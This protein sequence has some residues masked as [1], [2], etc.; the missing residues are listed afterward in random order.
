MRTRVAHSSASDLPQ[1]EWDY[2]R[3][4]GLSGIRSVTSRSLSLGTSGT[5]FR[6]TKPDINV[7]PV[8]RHVVQGCLAWLSETAIFANRISDDRY[9]PQLQFSVSSLLLLSIATGVALAQ[10][11][12]PLINQPLVPDA[13]KPVSAGF[14]LTVN[15]TGFVSGAVVKWNGNARTTTFVSKSRLTAT[16]LSTDVAKVNRIGNC[17][18]SH[19]GRW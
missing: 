11:P 17:G 7:G 5:R 15:G 4:R 2:R 3:R 1:D 18:E 8:F 6:C 9:N 16:I 14:T 19:A 10:N 13:I 12:V